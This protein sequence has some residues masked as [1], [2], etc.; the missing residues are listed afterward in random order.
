MEL[1]EFNGVDREPVHQSR[2]FEKPF[3]RFTGK[4]VDQMGA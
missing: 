1:M 2:G 4:P 3:R